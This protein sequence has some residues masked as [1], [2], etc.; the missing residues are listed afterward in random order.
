[1]SE[2]KIAI[3]SRKSKYTG[4]GESIN[5]QIEICKRKLNFTFDNLDYNN[6]VIIY[7]DEGY[8]GFNVKRPAFQRLLKDIRSNKIKLVV[9]Y[10]TDRVSRNV[11]DFSNL[12]AEFDKY[13]VQL[14]SATE[15][16]ETITPTGRAMLMMTSV[17]SQLERDTIA[18]RIRD[19]MME[20]AKSGRWLGGNA[21][22]GY[23]SEAIEKIT[24]D[25]KSKKLFK[26]TIVDEEINIVKIIFNK[27]LELQSQTK[28]ETFLIN[29]NI[30]TKT[31]INFSRF[32]I[33]NIL[34]NPVYAIA[35]E[36][37]YKYFQ[38]NDI[39]VFNEKE[40]FNGKFGIMAYNKT[41]Q[42]YNK[43]TKKRNMTEWIISIGKHKGIIPGKEWIEVQNII[44]GNKNKR[45][46]KPLKNNALLSGIIRC[47]HCGSFMRP[48]IR[49]HLYKDYEYRFTYM[50]EL[51]ERSRKGKCQAKD[52]GGNEIDEQIVK[53][54]K[55]IIKPSSNFYKTLK[56]TFDDKFNKS[57]EEND[58]LTT[59]KNQ[60]KKNEQE[61]SNLVEN[62][63]YV[64]KS[65]VNEISNEIVK[66]KNKNEEIQKGISKIL[67]S[68]NSF[69]INTKEQAELVLSIIDNYIPK[70]NEL[71]ILQKRTLIKM[72]ISSVET[73]GENLIINF[74]GARN[75][76]D[77]N[78]VPL[79]ED[80][81]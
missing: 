54:I 1:M 45:Y 29:N 53:T 32:A 59:F 4:K 75:T 76:K 14:M 9:Y 51:K 34:Q 77:N 74:V 56:K 19:N 26:L 22:T 41:E 65:I 39:E 12:M 30:K 37:L 62:I 49:T 27:Y 2:R 8:T 78:L 11:N 60:Y 68:N 79:C 28:L 43:T 25:G 46:R 42:K 47:S 80:S 48:K 36:D 20:L 71:D 3:Y 63:K 70:F 33:K 7:E 50:C 67:S 13:D 15:N 69:N 38:E 18:E 35:D 21:P 64:D 55:D 72:L 23:Q 52:V 81:K 5:N 66:L 61:I 16:I 17:F 58:E 24:V 31:G 6:D 73:D 57:T 40:E 44:L 10:R